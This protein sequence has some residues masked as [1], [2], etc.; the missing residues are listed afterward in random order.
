M[1][2]ALFAVVTL[3]SPEPVR[4]AC[5]GLT[6]FQVDPKE[7]E[8]YTE[9]L[10][11]QFFSHGI[12]V[13]TQSEI[14]AM[15][16]LERQ[17]QLLGCEDQS[18][19]FAELAGALGVDGVITG[20]LAKLDDAYAITVKILAAKDGAPILAESARVSSKTALLDWLS[21]FSKTAS[22][23]LLDRRQGTDQTPPVT[24][25]AQSDVKSSGEGP[26][27]LKVWLPAA[28]GGA[29][30]VAGGVATALA[31]SNHAAI[32]N[33]DPTITNRTELN[34]RK[35]SGETMNTVGVALIAAGV[36]GLGVAAVMAFTGA[37]EPPP[38][39]LGV[40]TDAVAVSWEVRF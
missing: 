16:G 30:I 10:S 3:A 39:A 26:S 25:Q 4:L 35:R 17:K 13:T 2:A 22:A 15:I 24:A 18:T 40:T 21:A 27:K 1:L 11:Q 20:N 19:C 31:I 33:G 38:V 6:N 5:P 29:L 36:A 9:Y 34:E 14:G 32:S 12:R 8:F 23:R 28:A 7:A 37:E